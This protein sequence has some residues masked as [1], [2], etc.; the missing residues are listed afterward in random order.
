MTVK[1]HF[2][3]VFFFFGSRSLVPVLGD[4]YLCSTETRATPL[5]K[6]ACAL[7]KLFWILV[8]CIVHGLSWTWT[9]YMCEAATNLAGIK[10]IRA[11]LRT[12]AKLIAKLDCIETQEM[13]FL[14]LW[15][16]AVCGSCQ[17]Q[18][19]QMPI[20]TDVLLFSCGQ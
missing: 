20:L 2:I 7:D 16:Q 13:M 14:L 4:R 9:S 12:I 17:G 10:K 8:S 11:S 15:K 5:M 3:G 1:S 18:T 6:A 19:M